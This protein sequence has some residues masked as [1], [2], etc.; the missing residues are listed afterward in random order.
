MVVFRLTDFRYSS[1]DQHMTPG[2]ESFSNLY[3]TMYSILPVQST[4]ISHSIVHA[5]RDST[6]R[7]A[8]NRTT[9]DMQRDAA[10]PRCLAARATVIDESQRHKAASLRRILANA[11]QAAK[12]LG[13]EVR[14]K[15]YC[16]GH[17]RDTNA[18]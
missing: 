16:A 17:G 18:R 6:G 14:T 9:H 3:S 1:P 15:R 2:S 5:G 12:V 13:G 7:T 11:G 4:K 8:L 10:M